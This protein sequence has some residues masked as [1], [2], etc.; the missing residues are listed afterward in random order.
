MSVWLASSK[1]RGLS[2]YHMRPT[3]RE[4]REVNVGTWC[5]RRK[6]PSYEY[7]NSQTIID[8]ANETNADVL[9]AAVWYHMLGRQVRAKFPLGALGLYASLLPKFKG[10]TPLNWAILSGESETGISLFEPGDGVDDGKVY[11]QKRFPIA[12]D[13]TITELVNTAEVGALELIAECLP[14]IAD[15]SLEPRPQHGTA[16]H[17]L[18]HKPEDRRI[19]WKISAIGI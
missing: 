18:Q 5:E 11:G 13:T 19:D 16:S 10:G 12:S 14:R 17:C 6:I 9:L 1:S 2:G 4:M 7:E 15:R 8:S 3:V